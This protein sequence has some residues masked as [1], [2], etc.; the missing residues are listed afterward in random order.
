MRKDLFE[1]TD[2]ARALQILKDGNKRYVTGNTLHGAD[3][4]HARSALAEKGQTP[5]AVVFGCSDSRV[6]PEIVFDMGI[7]ELFVVRT[8][9]NVAD[10]ISVG[11]VEFAVEHLHARVVLVLGHEK[12][13]AVAAAVA[14]GEHG[15]NIGA[16]IRE[17][18]PSIERVRAEG[19]H[20]LNCR[21]EDENI[22]HTVSE[23]GVS[24]ILSRYV[25]EGKLLITGAK[26][27]LIS[28]EVNFA[29]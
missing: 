27:N 7:G 8:A 16:I 25:D 12:C 23:L 24:P 13:G 5:L 19:G 11:S 14:G 20:D 10:A 9:G 26:Y 21:C 15:P 1:K 2:S 4:S 18:E 22:R 28:G 3:Y 17:I 6:P 29:I